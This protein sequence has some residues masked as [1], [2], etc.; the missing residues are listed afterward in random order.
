M[1]HNEK[2]II[3]SGLLLT[4][5][6]ANLRLSSVQAAVI[7]D[8]MIVQPTISNTFTVAQEQTGDYL[9]PVNSYNDGNPT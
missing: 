1:I 4:L 8:T 2:R 5:V 7:L 6:L 3:I 9:D